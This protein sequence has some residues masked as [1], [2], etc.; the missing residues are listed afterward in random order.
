MGVVESAVCECGDGLQTPEHVLQT[1]T[2]L[3]QLRLQTW[4]LSTDMSTKL[5]GTRKDLE[6]TTGF[7]ALA[8]LAV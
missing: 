5:W 3:N 7:L 6:G 2:R 1:C 8:G 4:P